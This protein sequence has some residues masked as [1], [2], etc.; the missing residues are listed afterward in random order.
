M[1]HT[2]FMLAVRGIPQLYYGE[3]IA[4]K[5]KE[6]PDNRRDF[7]GGFP[8]DSL[9]AFQ[10][11]TRSVEQQR[12]W[13]STHDWIKLRHDHPALREGR[14]VDIFYDDDAYV[15]ARQ[16]DTETVMIAINGSSNA[17][18]IAFSTRLFGLG[19]QDLFLHPLIGKPDA[20][21]EKESVRFN[22]PPRSA[23]A[24]SIRGARQ[25]SN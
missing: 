7:P 20:I 15:Y 19:F 10:T 16:D 5:G 8:G 9:S 25:V 23:M 14:L 1:L 21:L 12:V 24:Y 13:Q 17:K 3:E 22:L 2:A 11:T 6:D 4:M 18:S